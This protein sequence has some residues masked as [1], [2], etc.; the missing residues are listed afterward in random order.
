M[1]QHHL[2]VSC[3]GRP[4]RQGV[5]VVEKIGAVVLRPVS[6]HDAAPPAAALQEEVERS[7][8]LER[9]GELQASREEFLRRA[10][11]LD[12]ELPGYTRLAAVGPDDEPCPHTPQLAPDGDFR[13]GY[14]AG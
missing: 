5:L 1:R 7:L 3:A 14:V 11:P 10:L 13:P 4:S 12:T 8:D 9:S 2:I 6:D